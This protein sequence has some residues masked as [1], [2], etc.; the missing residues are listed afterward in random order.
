MPEELVAAVDLGRI[1]GRLV[2]QQDVG[3][4]IGRLTVGGGE[5]DPLVHLLDGPTAVDEGV[6]HPV[7]EFG[8]RRG[9]GHVPEIVRR[10]DDAGAEV[11]GPETVDEYAR[12][13]RIGA[14]SDGEGE[15]ATAAAFIERQAVGAGKDLEELTRSHGSALVAVTADVDIAVAGLRD[16]GDH[17]GRAGAARVGDIQRVDVAELEVLHRLVVIDEGRADRGLPVGAKVTALGETLQSGHRPD[18]LDVG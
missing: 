4:R 15:L 10:G 18:I 1:H 2:R 6:G 5:E 3:V 16:V 8:V 7:E 11:M 14:A 12:R 9:F 17:H 13:Q